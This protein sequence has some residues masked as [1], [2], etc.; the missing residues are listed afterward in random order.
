MKCQKCDNNAVISDPVLCKEHY[1][2]WF[3]SNVEDTVNKYNLLSHDEK[4]AV[5]CSG[6]KDSTSI[7]YILKRMGFNLDAI[8]IDEGIPGY[9]DSTLV[10]LKKFCDSHDITLKTFS[11]NNDFGFKLQDVRSKMDSAPCKS[12]GILRRYLLNKYSFGYDKIVTGHNLDDEF[13]NIMMNVLKSNVDV[14]LR[15]GPVTG[16]QAH[17]GFVQRV[18]P[19]YFMTEKQVLTYS[20]LKGFD[21]HYTQCPNASLGYRTRVRD[22]FFE[23]EEEIPGLRKNSVESFLSLSGSFESPETSP[24]KCENCGMPSKG[25]VCSVCNTVKV[26]SSQKT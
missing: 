19:L 18:K 7:L 25:R 1:T 17:D 11:F 5:A 2:S 9:R 16:H 6:G 20:L 13:Q 14:L 12:C 15:L 10:D 22:L 24:G 21:I 8:A 4:I 26:L 3:E 23:L